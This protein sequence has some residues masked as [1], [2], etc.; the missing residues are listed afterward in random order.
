MNNLV[1]LGDTVGPVLQTTPLGRAIAAAIVSSNDDVEVQDEGAYLRIMA[2]GSC[3][4]SKADVEAEFGRAVSL[5]GD[6]EVTMSSFAGLVSMSENG[7][8]WWRASDPEPR[9]P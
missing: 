1:A 6:L 2:H 7:A 8:V 9:I 4:L 3:R 5:P